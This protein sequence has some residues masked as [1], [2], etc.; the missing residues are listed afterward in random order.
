MKKRFSSYSI[1]IIALVAFSG[2]SKDD[3]SS[4]YDVQF[5]I[6][7]VSAFSPASARVGDTVTISG[8]TLSSIDNAWVNDQGAKVISSSDSQ[9]K[10]VVGLGSK[11]GKI[12][13]RNVYRQVGLSANA[14]NIIP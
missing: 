1:L 10:V 13:V 7:V 2:C 12:K 3:W 5:P 4:D 14:I 9:L 6:P 8:T 11:T